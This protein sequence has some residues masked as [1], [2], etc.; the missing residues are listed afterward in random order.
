MR[1]D[2]TQSDA[3]AV[4][5]I[6]FGLFRLTARELLADAR[7]FVTVEEIVWS[8]QEAEAEVDRLNEIHKNENV[9]FSWSETRVRRRPN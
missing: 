1:S 5:R 4:L 9:L 6:E 7:P 2:P 8:E 3:F